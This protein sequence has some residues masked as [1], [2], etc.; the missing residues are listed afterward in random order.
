MHGK[1]RTA[2][3]A[4]SRLVRASTEVSKPR[5]SCDAPSSSEPS[6]VWRTPGVGWSSH[7]AVRSVTRICPV[8]GVD[9]HVEPDHCA[10]RLRAV[11]GGDDHLVAGDRSALGADVEAA[12]GKGADVIGAR[13][14]EVVRAMYRERCVKAAHELQRIGVAVVRGVGAAGH[15]RPARR[16]QLANPRGVQHLVVVTGVAGRLTESR[17]HRIETGELVVGQCR[18]HPARASVVGRESA[19]LDKRIG[20]REP[21]LGR[22]ARP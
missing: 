19:I 20:E 13:A 5:S 9:R 17:E 14:G 21:A 15:L 12:A 8:L 11:A 10:E 3:W 7:G 2:R 6:S 22:C 18:N 1:T 16:Q 4:M